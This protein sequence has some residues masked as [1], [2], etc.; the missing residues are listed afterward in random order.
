M[1]RQKNTI[2]S[3]SMP[4]ETAESIKKIATS[5]GESVSGMITGLASQIAESDEN[6]P[7]IIPI[8]SHKGGV[9]KTTTAG[10]LSICL[11]ELGYKVLA[12]DL[13]GQANLTDD[14]Y[15]FDVDDRDSITAV[16]LT[17]SGSRKKLSQVIVKTRFKNLDLVPSTL[18]HDNIDSALILE[19]TGEVT[20][21]L[22]RAIEV[23]MGSSTYDY[24]IIDC[25][26]GLGMNVT[27]AILA[28]R[29]GSSKS[30]TLIPAKTAGSAIKGVKNTIDVIEQIAEE[31]RLRPQ[32]YYVLW[33]MVDTRSKILERAYE[34]AAEEIDEVPFLETTIPL[35][36]DVQNGDLLNMPVVES[37]PRG[38]ASQAYR[39][40]A[41]E[42]EGLTQ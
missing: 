6:S 1:A 34:E 36:V 27:N 41:K 8:M 22:S 40:L 16:M 5:K 33:T 29:V 13:D 15:G 12:I 39:K 35:R 11:A 24:I 30:F 9:A 25:P 28:M 20:L 3:V 14:I 37:S 21:R 38:T 42:I 32:H 19:T 2:V 23:L 26:P 7:V 17:K 31:R 18:S 4:A 10:N